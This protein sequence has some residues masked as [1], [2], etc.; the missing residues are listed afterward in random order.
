MHLKTFGIGRLT[1]GAALL[2]AVFSG[3]APGRE[4]PRYGVFVYSNLCTEAQSGDTAGNRITIFRYPYSDFLMFEYTEAA[5]MWPLLGNPTIDS[6][7]GRWLSRF[8]A[9]GRKTCLGNGRFRGDY[10]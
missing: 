1:A 2:M 4:L 10:R 7:T 6:K 5:L 3:G 8:A 9:V